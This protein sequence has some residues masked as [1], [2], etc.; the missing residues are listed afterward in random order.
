LIRD[1]VLERLSWLMAARGVPE[2]IRSDNEPESTVRCV[3]RWPGD[4][5]VKALFIEPGRPM[6]NGYVKGFSRTGNCGASG[7]IEIFL[8][9]ARG[10]GV[11]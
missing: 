4:V 7:W 9:S 5:Q 8:P 2:Y 1:D 11:D 3:R 10:Q 6:E